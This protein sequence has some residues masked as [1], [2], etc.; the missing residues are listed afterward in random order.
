MTGSLDAALDYIARGWAPVSVPHREKGPLIDAWQD[1]RVNAETAGTYFNGAKQNIGVILGEASG[2][3]TD[4]DLDCPE[5]VAAAPY[6]LPKTAVFGHASKPASH[7]VY[8]TNLH[9]TQ[10]RAAIKLMSSDKHGLLEVRMG[11]NGMAAQTVFPPSTHRETGEPIAWTERGPNEV[12][13]VAGDVLLQAARRLAAASE[14]ARH[15]PKVGGRHDGAFVIG[16]FLTRC[17]F[18]EAQASLFVEAIGAASLQP[19]DKRRDMARTARDGA[20]AGK[21]AGFP[22][23]AETF[24]K[25]PATKVADWLGYAAE[26]PNAPTFPPGAEDLSSPAAEVI[27]TRAPYD[28]AKLFQKGLATPARY[29]RGAFYEWNGASWPEVDE[30]KLRS[31]LYAFLDRCQTRTAKGAFCAVKPNPAMV[32]GVLDGLRG[33]AYLDEGIAPPAWLDGAEGPPAHEIVACANGLLH[34]P[35]RRLLPHSPSFFTL[36]ALDYDYDPEAPPP[37]AWN[38]FLRDLWPEDKE[39]V[40]ALKQAFGYLL[41]SDTSQQKAFLIIGPRRS[42]KGTIGRV[43][44]RFVGL[45]NFVA[46]TLAS[47]SLERFALAPLIGKPLAV[48]SDARLSGRADQQVIVERLLSITG[49]DGQTIDRKFN[50]RPWTGT[51]PTRFVILANQLPRTRRRQRSARWPLHSHVADQKLLR[52]RGPRP[53]QQAA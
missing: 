39:S 5:A 7:W 10:D 12:A 45:H 38:T 4:L 9:K 30:D 44:A 42:G 40:A 34:L 31:R 32:S 15:Y 25:G 35:T 16:G 29:H 8:R 53:D 18:T 41:T 24:G 47:L 51:L 49:E 33:T 21:R 17:G 11:A 14:L 19:G 20:T 46:P 26:Q 6:I 3:L 2:G 43:L 28:N 48:V 37:F 36:N 13:D 52:A 23:L 27:N 22:K 1:I 50:P